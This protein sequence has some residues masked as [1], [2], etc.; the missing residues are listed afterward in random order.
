MAFLQGIGSCGL[1]Y[2][3]EGCRFDSCK[4]H[5]EGKV[6]WFSILDLPNR[7]TH[8]RVLSKLTTQ[9]E[10]ILKK[11]AAERIPCRNLLDSALTSSL[12]W[13]K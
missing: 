5:C 2:G 10:E 12:I 11:V 13:F 9:S 8:N 1:V 4:L 6:I 7:E 3:T